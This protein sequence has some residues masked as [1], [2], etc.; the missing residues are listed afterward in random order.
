MQMLALPADAARILQ[1]SA[2]QIAL[3]VDRGVLPIVGRTVRGVRVLSLRD[4]ENFA[5][6]QQA[7]R[8]DQ[9]NA[10]NNRPGRAAAIS[11]ASLGSPAGSG[12]DSA[13]SVSR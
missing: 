12:S 1:C 7:K 9:S 5:R 11:P 13:L 8:S 6:Q 10:A 4:V 3:L 2:S